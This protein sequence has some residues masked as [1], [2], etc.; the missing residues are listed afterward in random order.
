MVTVAI[1]VVDVKFMIGIVYDAHPTSGGLYIGSTTTIPSAGS[2][3]YCSHAWPIYGID[4]QHYI[5][6]SGITGSSATFYCMYYN[7]GYQTLDGGSL[8]IAFLT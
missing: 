5:F 7:W 6:T 2:A 1:N 3:L 4:Y 8:A